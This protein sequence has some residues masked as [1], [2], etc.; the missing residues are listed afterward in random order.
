M[1]ALDSDQQQLS[2]HSII[3]AVTDPAVTDPAI[4]DK[5]ATYTAVKDAAN[6]SSSFWCKHRSQ[7]QHKTATAAWV[8]DLTESANPLGHACP[9]VCLF[10]M[11]CASCHQAV[12]RYVF[13]MPHFNLASQTCTASL[14]PP[15]EGVIWLTQMPL[16]I[17]DT[18]GRQMLLAVNSKFAKSWHQ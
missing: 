12:T 4:T 3:M 6:W 15:P 18:C 9:V 8:A 5:A 7:Q 16:T 1:A 13:G 14:F 10:D 11:V 17:C 2:N